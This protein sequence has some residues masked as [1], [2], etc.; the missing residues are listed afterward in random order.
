MGTTAAWATED[1]GIEIES[2][3]G[4]VIGVRVNSDGGAGFTDSYVAYPDEVLGVSG[5]SNTYRLPTLP[6]TGGKFKFLL[7]HFKSWVP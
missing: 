5:G 1:K 3:D 6:A 7:T 4:E 2:L